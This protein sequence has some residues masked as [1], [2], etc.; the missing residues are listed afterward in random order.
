MPRKRKLCI[1]AIALTAV[2]LFLAAVPAHAGN[3]IG[4]GAVTG[5]MAYGSP[6]IPQ[7]LA[8]GGPKCDM[9]VEFSAG[10]GALVVDT[11]IVGYAGPVTISNVPGELIVGGQPQGVNKTN[12]ESFLLGSGRLSLDIHG[13]N[14]VNGAEIKCDNV[15][16]TWIRVFYA[17]EIGLNGPC[18]IG[19]SF[20]TSR[21]A[22]VGA[23][24]HT[25]DAMDVGGGVLHPYTSAAVNGA[26]AISP[27]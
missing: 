16:G 9:T 6:G 4:G 3:K 2:A 26:F 5:T 23:L 24:S 21:I 1:R 27:G 25:P 22:F 17:L 12:C 8:P 18:L 15:D 7:P 19:G 10:A 14:E 11:Q 20:T 13:K